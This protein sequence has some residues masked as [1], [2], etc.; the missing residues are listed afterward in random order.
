M[1]LARLCAEIPA[2]QPQQTVAGAS[3]FLASKRNP[4]IVIQDGDVTMMT[5][6][7]RARCF[8]APRILRASIRCTGSLKLMGLLHS[9]CQS[10]LPS[11]PFGISVKSRSSSTS[12]KTSPE[13]Q[14]NT[15]ATSSK[16]A[17]PPRACNLCGIEQDF[18]LL[19]HHRSSHL[20]W[21]ATSSTDWSRSRTA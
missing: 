14:G 21:V 15:V 7:S 5:V 12:P 6:L 17:S 13:A 3:T 1:P 11:Q 19:N 2:K 16:I 4:H 9:R 10:S 20:L 8:T 18:P